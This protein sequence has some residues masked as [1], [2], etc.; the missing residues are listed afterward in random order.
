MHLSQRPLHRKER[1]PNDVRNTRVHN[2]KVKTRQL[3]ERTLV[4]NSKRG[5]VMPGNTYSVPEKWY[6][7]TGNTDPNGYTIYEFPAGE[8][9][10]HP[11]SIDDVE[12]RLLQLPEH[13]RSYVEVIEL[14]RQTRKKVRENLYGQ[15]W[16][17]AVYLY[18]VDDSLIEVFDTKD[19]ALE[20]DT[21]KFGGKWHPDNNKW[22]LEW[23]ESTI[24]DYY[25]ENVLL[26]EVGHIVD[27]HNSRYRDRESFANAFAQK[28]RKK[29]ARSKKIR[30]RHNTV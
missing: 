6:E 30:K 24:R 14:S 3:T 13:V 17:T 28:H 20:H 7:P 22:I 26:H 8:G 23:T 1:V 4:H 2:T 29:R 11:A 12:G 18:P 5:L 10:M 19:A 25:L 9:Y 21:K 15:Q 16:G 27:S